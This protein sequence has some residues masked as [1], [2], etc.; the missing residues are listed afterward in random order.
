LWRP[1][2]QLVRNALNLDCWYDHGCLRGYFALGGGRRCSELRC[3]FALLSFTFY[4]LIEAVELLN[5]SCKQLC[6]LCYWR[7]LSSVQTVSSYIIPYALVHMACVT[8]ELFPTLAPSP[9]GVVTP[10]RRPAA[11]TT[12]LLLQGGDAWR[13]TAE[14]CRLVILAVRPSRLLRILRV[15]TF[16]LSPFLKRQ[17]LSSERWLRKT[18]SGE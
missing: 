16:I 1:P 8:S 13:A 6:Y 7:S 11:R 2:A 18:H 15:H 10:P 5:V 3:S 17:G 14:P 9:P 4:M 12:T